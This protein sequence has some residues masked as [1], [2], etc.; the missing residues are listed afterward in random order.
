MI[1][2]FQINS[3]I[4]WLNCAFCLMFSFSFG[5]TLYQGGNEVCPESLDSHAYCIHMHIGLSESLI[6]TDLLKANL[7]C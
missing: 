6:D 1:C 5:L 2:A 7:V 4:L 3:G